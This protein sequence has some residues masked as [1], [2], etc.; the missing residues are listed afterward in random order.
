MTLDQFEVF[1]ILNNAQ[2]ISVYLLPA[3]KGYFLFASMFF[4]TERG[5]NCKVVTPL[6]YSWSTGRLCG[7]KRSRDGLK[8]WRN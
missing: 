5:M 2:C 1:I 8:S 6:K 3:K 7:T 4:S